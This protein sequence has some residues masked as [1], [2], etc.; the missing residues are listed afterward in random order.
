MRR[1]GKYRLAALAGIAMAGTISC[2]GS[3]QNPA[4]HGA[5]A[6]SATNAL[7]IEVQA[8]ACR[9]ICGNGRGVQACLIEE[10]MDGC[11]E[12]VRHYR[13]WHGESSCAS[14]SELLEKSRTRYKT[15]K[16]F[17]WERLPTASELRDFERLGF[18][19]MEDSHRYDGPGYSGWGGF[20]M[21]FEQ[22]EPVSGNSKGYE[23]L[24]YPIAIRD[25]EVVF[26][27]S[28]MGENSKEIC[29]FGIFTAHQDGKITPDRSII[30][31]LG[32]TE[33]KTE[34]VDSKYVV[35]DFYYKWGHAYHPVPY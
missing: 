34:V 9:K 10:M 33:F 30:D 24:F 16:W 27:I 25:G 12:N 15:T 4:V 18:H 22:R 21:K 32:I 8:K 28:E 6:I 1:D 35:F 2:S 11:I 23:T 14:E 7:K 13:K 19:A 3:G 17:D 5:N 20:Y 26:T 31:Y 29:S